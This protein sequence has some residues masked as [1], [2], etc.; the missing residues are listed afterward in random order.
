MICGKQKKPMCILKLAYYNRPWYRAASIPLFWRNRH[1]WR[2]N[3]EH[4]G[5]LVTRVLLYYAHARPQCDKLDATLQ[6]CD[7]DEWN[8]WEMLSA[9]ASSEKEP[10]TNP[11]NK[12]D[13]KPTK[14]TF[15]CFWRPGVLSALCC[16]CWWQRNENG[17]VWISVIPHRFIICMNAKP[18]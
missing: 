2:G 11:I 13:L 5:I 9:A 16:C 3:I 17:D 18:G 7:T 6:V 14:A 4:G 8:F 1:I 12:M 10:N 15:F